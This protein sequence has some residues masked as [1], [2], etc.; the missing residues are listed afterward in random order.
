MKA[1][2]MSL[3]MTGLANVPVAAQTALPRLDPEGHCRDQWTENGALN[4][5]MMQFCLQQEQTAYDSL[6][7]EW[8]QLDRSIQ[9]TCLRDWGNPRNPNSSYRML[10]FCTE[11]QNSARRQGGGFRW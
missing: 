4:H 5:R 10:R 6:R 1:L 2:L 9:V 3:L 7:S 8:P 11:Q